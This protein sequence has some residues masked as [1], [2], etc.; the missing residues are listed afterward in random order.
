MNTQP[1]PTPKVPKT[2]EEELNELDDGLAG[3][4]ITR[5]YTAI[6]AEVIFWGM[7]GGDHGRGTGDTFVEALRD[8]FADLH[9]E[10]AP[11]RPPLDEPHWTEILNMHKIVQEEYLKDPEHDK[12]SL[13]DWLII[14]VKKGS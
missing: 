8:L 2:I 14:R 7:S 5:G 13:L 10:P 4:W 1:T 12:I 3:V 6:N 11:D 9:R